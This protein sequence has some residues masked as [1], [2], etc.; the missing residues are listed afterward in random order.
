MVSQRKYRRSTGKI[1]G[2]S[3]ETKKK[4]PT[5]PINVQCHKTT[6]TLENDDFFP[7]NRKKPYNKKKGK[8]R[9]YRCAL[10]QMR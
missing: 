2:I 4:E 8:V 3:I 9:L 7:L 6:T 10:E 1:N 5:T